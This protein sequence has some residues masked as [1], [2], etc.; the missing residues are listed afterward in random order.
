MRGFALGDMCFLLLKQAGSTFVSEN[1][2]RLCI[3][4][5]LCT[6]LRSP[7]PAVFWRVSVLHRHKAGK[8][9]MC[10][11]FMENVE[12]LWKVTKYVGLVA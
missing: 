6:L 5:L 4:L 10:G 11:R 12:N 3:I 7:S 2:R 1:R 8:W 9:K